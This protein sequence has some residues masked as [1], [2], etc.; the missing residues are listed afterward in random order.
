MTKSDVDYK[1]IS[2]ED[3]VRKI[4]ESKRVAHIYSME[5]PL[6]EEFTSNNVS[7][8]KLVQAFKLCQIQRFS[9]QD[10]AGTAEEELY[11]MSP[12]DE[13]S[14]I[15]R[16][17]CAFLMDSFFTPDY[18]LNGAAQDQMKRVFQLK[19]G[20]NFR[21]NKHYTTVITPFMK[22]INAVHPKDIPSMNIEQLEYIVNVDLAGF[23]FENGWKTKLGL[24]K[25]LEVSDSLLTEVNHC[26]HFFTL[27]PPTK[28]K[29]SYSWKHDVEAKHGYISNSAAIIALYFFGYGYQWKWDRRADTN[30]NNSLVPLRLHYLKSDN[31]TQLQTLF[32]SEDISSSDDI[33][34]DDIQVDNDAE[35]VNDDSSD[36]QNVDSQL[37]SDIE[38]TT[39][40]TL[41]EIY[42]PRDDAGDL[43]SN[44][45]SVDSSD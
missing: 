39:Q 33:S 36:Q 29:S 37:L 1:K 35:I 41:T 16:I 27:H 14:P 12:R 40:H 43:H 6:I 2:V 44:E 24:N 5:K 9:E 32:I 15:T 26:I 17:I 42:M 30:V 18:Y 7:Q 31:V 45:E 22:M 20:A 13:A 4:I 8:H 28:R 21:K 11:A 23:I 25:P 19:L 3:S 10:A 34:S 38:F